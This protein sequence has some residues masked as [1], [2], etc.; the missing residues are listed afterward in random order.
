MSR[1]NFP[2][3]EHVLY[4]DEVFPAELFEGPEF[5]TARVGPYLV[6]TRTS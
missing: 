3:T 4:Y 6:A 1:P 5:R 2:A